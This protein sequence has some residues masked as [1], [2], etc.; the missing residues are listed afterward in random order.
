MSCSENPRP[1]FMTQEVVDKCNEFNGFMQFKQYNDT[2]YGPGIASSYIMRN[3][4]YAVD[5]SIAGGNGKK[6]TLLSS[7]D[8]TISAILVLLGN[9]H[10][11]MPPYASYLAMEI[12]KDKEQT[13]YVRYVFNGEPVTIKH[14]NKTIVRY[15]DFRHYISP[16]IDYCHDF[17][18]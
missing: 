1:D 12:L 2:R 18:K 11:Y 16:L 7:H 9:V 4:F 10:K 13:Y 5:D 8:T 3:S 6:F 15:D 17:P 14:F